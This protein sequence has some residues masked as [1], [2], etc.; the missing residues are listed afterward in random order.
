MKSESSLEEDLRR[1]G[2]NN[3]ASYKKINKRNETEWIIKSDIELKDKLEDLRRIRYA[4]GV[5]EKPAAYKDIL[6]AAFRF[7]PLLDI[8]KKAEFKP[9][10]KNK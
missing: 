2:I 4:N 7:Q 9:K 6:G 10:E 5:D 8:L 3:L 1:G